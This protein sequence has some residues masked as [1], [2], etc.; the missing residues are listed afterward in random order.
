MAVLVIDLVLLVGLAL[1]TIRLRP[2]FSKI[3]DDFETELPGMTRLLLSVPGWLILLGAVLGAAVIGL[4]ELLIREA[5]VNL[6][7]NLAVLVGLLGLGAVAA[8]ALMLPL[9]TLIKALS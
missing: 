9:V 5:R 8:V 3:F 6:M 2:T 1:A 4:K 7:L